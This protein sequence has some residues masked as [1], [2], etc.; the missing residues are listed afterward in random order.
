MFNLYKTKLL[1]FLTLSIALLTFLQCED[2][3][4]PV[5]NTEVNI[6][7]DLNSA[8]FNE[9]VPGNYTYITGGVNGIII[10]RKNF[11]EFTAMDRT[12]PYEAAYG[13]RVTVDPENEL[14]LECD[15]CQ[16]RY[17]IETGSVTQGPSEFPLKSYQTS[18]DGRFLRIYN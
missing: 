13:T 2:E 6:T 4:N 17:Y 16:S 10:Y 14:Y 7:I 11:D 18:F 5:P 8:E 3:Q 1:Q 15:T 9:L 12:C